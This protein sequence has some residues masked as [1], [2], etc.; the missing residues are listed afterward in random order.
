MS[1][2][3]IVRSVEMNTFLV[4]HFP[5]RIDAVHNGYPDLMSETDSPYV[6]NV[7]VCKSGCHQQMSKEF[8]QN[9][10]RYIE[11]WNNLIVFVRRVDL[12]DSKPMAS[13][14]LRNVLRITYY[15]IINSS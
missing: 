3:G 6:S 10:R 14:L 9:I 13:Y 4:C 12:L 5:V 8:S 1:S 15:I 11:Y 7:Y 2:A